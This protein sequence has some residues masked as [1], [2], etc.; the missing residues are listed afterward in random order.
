MSRLEG[1][2]NGPRNRRESIDAFQVMLKDC[3]TTNSAQLRDDASIPPRYNEGTASD[4]V[5]VVA[6]VRARRGQAHE[7][8]ASLMSASQGSYMLSPAADTSK[9]R[10]GGNDER[11]A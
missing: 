6:T 11:L 1:E 4:R 3:D 7:C 5:A 9:I 8:V 2:R 10:L